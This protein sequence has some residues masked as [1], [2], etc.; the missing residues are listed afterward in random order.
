MMSTVLWF[1][2]GKG[3]GYVQLEDGREAF[4]YGE[5]IGGD[6]WGM[7]TSWIPGSGD[8]LFIEVSAAERAYDFIKKGDLV[9]RSAKRIK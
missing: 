5:V 4:L 7:N 8:R 9:V 2:Q 1:N 6:A 3:Y